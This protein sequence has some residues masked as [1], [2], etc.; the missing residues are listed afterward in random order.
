MRLLNEHP[1]LMCVEVVNWRLYNAGFIWMLLWQAKC[2]KTSKL[3]LDM[4]LSHYPNM[5]LSVVI[6]M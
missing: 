2:D 4:T 3:R 6:D 1:Y 5:Y